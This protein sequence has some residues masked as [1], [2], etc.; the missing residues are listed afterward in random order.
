MGKMTPE[1]AKAHN[2]AVAVSMLYDKVLRNKE[3]ERSALFSP[4]KVR[5]TLKLR[6]KIKQTL[7]SSEGTNGKAYT[8]SIQRMADFTEGIIEL[9]FVT[10]KL[11]IQ[12]DFAK[13]IQDFQ[14]NVI[15]EIK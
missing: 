13:Y 3:L 14:Q 7:L 11:G 4:A 10:E 1:F 15:D 5:D 6:G 8:E 12:A 9:L 2:T